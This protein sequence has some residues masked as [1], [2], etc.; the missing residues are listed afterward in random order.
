MGVEINAFKVDASFPLCC[1]KYR[2]SKNEE[3]LTMKI[4]NIESRQRRLEDENYKKDC[5]IKKQM[6]ELDNTKNKFEEYKKEIEK[7][8]REE[9]EVFRQDNIKLNYENE[10]YQ[11]SKNISIDYN[12]K[13]EVLNRRFE[14]NHIQKQFPNNLL[15]SS[16]NQDDLFEA[17]PIPMV[18]TYKKKKNY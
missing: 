1:C 7:E 14:Q 18:V 16:N 11:K 6:I 10:F 13:G 4:N 2:N 17:S 9:K 8:K 5:L 3:A 12:K 15:M